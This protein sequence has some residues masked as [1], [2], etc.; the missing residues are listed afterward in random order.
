M[1]SETCLPLPLSAGKDVTTAPEPV[2]TTYGDFSLSLPALLLLPLWH[3]NCSVRSPVTR[4]SLNRW[5]ILRPDCSFPRLALADQ[6][7]QGPCCCDL[8]PSPLLSTPALHIDF[9]SALE[10]LTS[11]RQQTPYPYPKPIHT[12]LSKGI[13]PSVVQVLFPF[14]SSRQTYWLSLR[15]RSRI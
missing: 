3:Q 13:I 2:E 11:N 1:S 7:G 10:G 9:I 6:G 12:Q 5:S 15:N 4:T 8:W 14:F